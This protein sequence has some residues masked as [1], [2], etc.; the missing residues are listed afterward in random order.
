L[1]PAETDPSA[2][3]TD[4]NVSVPDLIY[5]GSSDWVTLPTDHQIPIYDG[6]DSKCKTFVSIIGGAIVILRIPTL[7][8]ILVRQHRQEEL[9]LRVRSNRRVYLQF[10]IHG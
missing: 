9:R 7:I 3:A 6:L 8:V 4:P 10:L 1:A 5:S 2:I